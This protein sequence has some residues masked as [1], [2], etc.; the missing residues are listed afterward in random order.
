M[1]IA[2]FLMFVTG[3]ILFCFYMGYFLF[4]LKRS[5]QYRPLNVEYSPSVSVILPTYNEEATIKSKLR[6]LLDQGYPVEIVLVDSAS[7]DRT[8]SLA[9]EFMQDNGLDVRIIAEKERRGK[10]SALNNAFNYCNH[11]IV[12]ITDSDSVWEKGAL[13]R[14]VS[15]FL[16]KDIGAVTGRQILMNADQ[17]FT[18]K[19]EK[20]YRSVYEVLRVGESVLDST[21]I[22]HGE[23]SCFRK[24]LIETIYERS[25]ADD[26]ELAIKIRK[27]GFRSIYDPAVVFYEYAPPTLASRFKQ[28]VRRGQGLIDLF[29]R[30]RGLVFNGRYGAF[31]RIVFPAEFFM[32]VVSPSLL[33]L[34]LGAFLLSLDFFSLLFGIAL[35]LL[36]SLLMLVSMKMSL[37]HLIFSFLQSQFI[38]FISLL[39]HLLGRSQ[40]KWGKIEEVRELWKK[41]NVP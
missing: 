37:I 13:K 29:L 16:D 12:V 35:L 32:H 11:E 14:A 28:K 3:S 23:I 22:F 25:M 10:A 26:S 36:S 30:E 40:H 24:D 9:M 38:L 41:E 5:R 39:N 7:Q 27:K 4:M 18:T 15:N 33:L 31:G 1:W 2:T 17:T 8:L 20:S 21:P 6:N 34:F 19:L